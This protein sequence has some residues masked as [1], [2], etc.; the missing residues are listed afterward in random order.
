MYGGLVRPVA[1][2]AVV[3]LTALSMAA[4]AGC[5]TGYKFAISPRSTVRVP[6]TATPDTGTSTSTTR[7]PG[8]VALCDASDLVARGGRRQNP[9]GGPGA[10]GDV[11]FANLSATACELKGIPGLRLVRAD[12]TSL[13]VQDA[14]PLSSALSAVVVQPHEKSTAEMVFTWDNWCEAAPGP[15]DMQISLTGGRGIVVAPLDGQLGSYVP[16]CSQRDSAS[17][18]RVQYAYVDSGSAPLSGA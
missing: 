13:A 9:D 18:L 3:G 11:I 5:D 6:S 17:V 2:I 15:L 10:I 12:S 16:G 4:L 7:V 1:V 8:D 14:S